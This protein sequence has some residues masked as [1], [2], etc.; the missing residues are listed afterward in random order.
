[1][2]CFLDATIPTNQHMIEFRSASMR[3]GFTIYP[4]VLMG[5]SRRAWI[6][7]RN[8]VRGRALVYRNRAHLRNETIYLKYLGRRR[9]TISTLIIIRILRSFLA[10]LL[11][12]SFP[13][14]Q[15]MLDGY[16]QCVEI[17]ESGR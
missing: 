11:L 5:A 14:K 10:C 9:L 12:C 16:V 7:D 2:A 13:E 6:F 15:Y 1:M 8:C 3:S 4:V 17:I